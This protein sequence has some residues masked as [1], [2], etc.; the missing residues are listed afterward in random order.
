MILSPKG[1]N[2]AASFFSL[3]LIVLVWEL[4]GSCVVESVHIL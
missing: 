4:A 1:E 3:F 2:G